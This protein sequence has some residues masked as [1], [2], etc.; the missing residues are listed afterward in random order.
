MFFAFGFYSPDTLR[1]EASVLNTIGDRVVVNLALSS[2]YASSPLAQVASTFIDPDTGIPF[3]GI[4]DPVHRVSY[5]IVLPPLATSGSNPTEFIASITSPIAGQWVGLALGGAMLQNLLLV[6]WPNGNSVVHSTRIAA[7]YDQ[8]TPYA[9]PVITDLQHTMVNAT[10]WKW[11][12]RCQNCT[13]WGTGGSLPVSGGGVLAWAYSSAPVITPSNPDSDFLEHTDFGFFGISYADAHASQADYDNWAAGG[14]GGGSGTPTSQP[15]TTPTS[16]PTVSATPYDY[17]VVG[18]G[19]GGLVTADRLSETGKKV[20]LLERGGPSTWETGGRY[21]PDWLAGQP[22]TKF[23]V[24][25]LFESM[26]SDGNQFWWCRD[27]NVFAGCLLGGGSTIN[28]GLYW[29]PP[30]SDFSVA[31]GWPSSWANHAPY[32]Q[33]MKTRL[34]STDHSSMDGIRYLPQSFNVAKRLLDPQG[35]RQLT[36]NDE[37]NQKDHVYGYSS[38]FFQ[39]GKRTGPTGTYFKT[40]KARPN[41]TYRDYT[42]VNS[43]IRNGTKV[44]GVQ[45]ND[46]SLGPDGFIPVTPHGRVILSG[47]SFGSP[48]LLFSAGIGPTDMLTI[49]QG[50]SVVGPKMPPQAQWINLP[51][52]EN[53]QDN[54][55]INL[56]FTHPDIDAY[57]NWADIMSDPRPADAAQY[58]SRQSGVFASSSPRMNFWRAYGGSDGKT[59]WMQGTVRPG[60][61]SVTSSNPYNASQIFTITTYLSTGITSKG[62][63]G[64]DVAL[65]PRVLVEPWFTDPIDKTVLLQGIND[66]VASVGN[67][68]GLTLITPDNITT[69]SSYVNNYGTGNMNSNHWIG[70][71]R[72]GSSASNSVVDPNAKVFGTDNLFVVDASIIPSMP[73]G[74]PQG[75]IMATAEQA[76]AKIIALAGGP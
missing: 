57:E 41:F 48:R 53:V 8:P 12:F 25:G 1:L 68:S 3:M 11:V 39:G 49:A 50:D 13:N 44:L 40:A 75:A 65:R 61:A 67:V 51:V 34:P 24:P 23:D 52:G 69:I 6:A 56:V 42:F 4:T 64:I 72:L 26:F 2:K 9:G 35:Y 43:I 46:T 60:A 29:Y 32:T 37:P 47:G 54:P 74:N 22:Y 59:R 28:G 16:Q 36:I 10:H 70:A 27:I 5:G 45:T 73:M 18:A 76:V 63:I 30:D 31:S 58:I 62:R 38:F 71:N 55:S 20:L 7:T 33:K 14:T 66:I 21:Q 15:P 17:I 19:P